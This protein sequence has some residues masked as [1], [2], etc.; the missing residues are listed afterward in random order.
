MIQKD[1]VHKTECLMTQQGSLYILKILL[2]LSTLLDGYYN[3][4]RSIM[5]HMAL[6]VKCKLGFFD[7]IVKQSD[8]SSPDYAARLITLQ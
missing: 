8:A 4:P 1:R 7:G 5:M 6:K 2:C 3:Q